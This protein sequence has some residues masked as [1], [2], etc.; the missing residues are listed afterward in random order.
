M[1]SGNTGSMRRNV[2]WRSQPGG[3]YSTTGDSAGQM[4]AVHDQHEA[5]AATSA[6]SPFQAPSPSRAMAQ[7]RKS[8]AARAIEW[9]PRKSA[10]PMINTA[11]RS[12]E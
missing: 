4:E 7:L 10:S 8:G 12:L 2:T 6:Y 9:T 1:S 5:T 3:V 11:I